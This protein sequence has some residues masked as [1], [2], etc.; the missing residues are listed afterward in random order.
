MKKTILLIIFCIFALFG[1]GYT[2][3]GFQQRAT[4]GWFLDFQEANSIEVLYKNKPYT[5][6]LEQQKKLCAL[7]NDSKKIKISKHPSHAE[8]QEIRIF[9]FNEQQPITLIPINKENSLFT[10]SRWKPIY[11]L[12]IQE[13]DK[14]KLLLKT[15]YD[16]VP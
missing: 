5:L 8:I 15:T 16:S 11:L 14:M 7:L 1:I 10:V 3:L 12:Q 13:P 2:Y 9:L 4:Q 6:N